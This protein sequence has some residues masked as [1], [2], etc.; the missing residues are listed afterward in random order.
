[1]AQRTI[2]QLL[3]EVPDDKDILQDISSNE[4][5]N[6]DSDHDFLSDDYDHRSEQEASSDSEDDNYEPDNDNDEYFSSRDKSCKW[7]KFNY[8]QEKQISD[9]VNVQETKS[10]AIQVS[11]EIDAFL[12]LIDDKMLDNIVI[13][14]NKK[15]ETKKDRYKRDRDVQN[16]TKNELLALFGLLFL[17]GVNKGNYTSSQELWTTDGTGIAML[18]ACMS[19]KRFS[20]LLRHLSFDDEETRSERK[21]LDKLASMRFFLDS[22][23]TN[24]KS[25]YMVGQFVA[26]KKL[27]LFEGQCSSGQNLPKKLA[28]SGIKVFVLCDAITYY[29]SNLEVCCGTQPDGPYRLSNKPADIVDRLVASIEGSNRNLTIGTWYTSYSLVKSLL[30]KKIT[31]V[32]AVSKNNSE[33]PVQFLPNKNKIVG[34]SIFGFQKDVTLVSYV[35]KINT[36][37]ILMSTMHHST[38]IDEKT[39]KPLIALHYDMTKGAVDIVNQLCKAYFISRVTNQWSLALF[40]TLMNVA[41]VNAQILYESN[42]QNSRVIRKKFLKNLVLSLMKN[43]L[44]ERAKILTLPAEI[45]AILAKYR[46]EPVEKQKENEESRKRGRCHLCTRAKNID[47]TIRCKICM[48]F[49]CRGH[50]ETTAICLECKNAK[51]NDEA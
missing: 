29:T 15:I 4:E 47:T 30:D 41:S 39:K 17:I 9:M 8:V 27:E 7:R 34:S 13:N 46:D 21:K 44:C 22:F 36:S 51:I 26:V 6:L 16:M 25:S 48:R 43:H 3:D 5:N 37:V 10:S 42:N 28:N 50:V 1:M 20:F 31:C 23:I 18:R 32:G 49:S 2:S 12:Q 38:I 35:P 45:R 24:C 40:F 11:S 33:I 19:N 14:T